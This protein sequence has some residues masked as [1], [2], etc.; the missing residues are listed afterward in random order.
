[1]V[2][3]VK[4]DLMKR[5][6]L[7]VV[8]GYRLHKL[9]SNTSDGD[10]NPKFVTNTRN[11]TPLCKSAPTW[12]TQTV[13]TSCSFPQF[14][15]SS[16]Q[17]DSFTLCQYRILSSSTLDALKAFYAERDAHSEKFSKLQAE[18]EE[19]LAAGGG[20]E[21]ANQDSLSMDLFTEDWNE[22]QF[23]VRFV[24]SYDIRWGERE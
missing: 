20:S 13:M 2:V 12:P 3:A 15:D 6:E 10:P 21:S 4:S 9:L 18:A 11:K 24:S 16:L 17:T 19:R 14:V 22:S 5:G 1:M 8:G 23:W 7:V